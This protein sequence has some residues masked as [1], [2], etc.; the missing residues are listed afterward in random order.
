MRTMHRAL[1]VAIA[2]LYAASLRAAEPETPP[3]LETLPD[4]PPPPEAVQSGEPLEPEVTIVRKKDATLE[5]Y[6]INGQLYMIKVTPVIGKPYYLLDQDGDGKMET[7][8]SEIYTNFTVP[9]WVLFSW[10]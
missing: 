8:M 6:R 1:L 10:K 4:A 7:N 2:L 5:E 9:Q 3:G